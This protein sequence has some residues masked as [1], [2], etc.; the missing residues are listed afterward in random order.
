LYRIASKVPQ[1]LWTEVTKYL[2][3]IPVYNISKVFSFGL[4]EEQIEE[5]K[6]KNIWY[7]IFVK[8]I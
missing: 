6:Y 4:T 1:E 8:D 7:S 5:Y 2:Q 3:P